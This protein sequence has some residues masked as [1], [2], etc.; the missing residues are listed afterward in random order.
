MTDDA[1]LR[2]I[3][4]DPDDDVPRLV[5]ADWL[6]E[7]GDPRGEFIRVQCRLATLGPED[8]R[9]PSLV[10]VERGLLERH[11]DEWLGPLRPLAS[12]WAFRRGFLDLVAVPAAVYL[13]RPAIPRPATVH[14]LEVDLDGF[15]APEP[16]VEFVPESVARENVLLPIGFRGRTLVLA[17]RKPWDGDTLAKIQF[18]VNS[19]IEPVAADERQLWEAIVRHYWRMMLETVTTECFF[20]PPPIDYERDVAAH[21]AAVARLVDLIIAEAQALHAD[22]IRI[23][24]RVENIRVLYHIGGVWTERDSPPRRLL[25]LI[26]ARVRL[27]AGL[28]FADEGVDQ[29]GWWRGTSGGRTFRL[30]V[31]IQ[32]TAEGPSATLT[33]LPATTEGRHGAG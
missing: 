32:P 28:L 14:R 15:E 25:D 24:P 31:L 27:L 12:R 2:A 10:R 20:E 17:M 3:L 26:V 30:R 23:E 18:I 33:F 13:D 22:Q 1:F 19:D 29:A 4:Q 7:R 5:Y 8:A 6:D 11:R 16:V 9:R 21:G